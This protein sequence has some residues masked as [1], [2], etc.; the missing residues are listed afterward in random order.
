VISAPPIKDSSGHVVAA[1]THLNCF[2]A[3]SDAKDAGPDVNQI[4]AC[5]AS[6]D[7]HETITYQPPSHYWPLQWYET[8]IF[9]A[10]TSL[11]SGFC[12][13]WIRR[14]QN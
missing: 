4:T 9:L 7:L 14:R 10:L 13:W 6:Y 8:G 3:P 5:L 11:L 12:F 1:H 2:P